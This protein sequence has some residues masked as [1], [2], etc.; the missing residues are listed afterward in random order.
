MALSEDLENTS[1]H[2]PVRRGL[3]TSTLSLLFSL[4]LLLVLAASAWVGFEVGQRQRDESS[5]ATQVAGLSSQLGLAQADIAAGRNGWAEERLRFILSI[6]PDF[7][8]AAA[9]LDQIAAEARL[10]SS[11]PPPTP[12]RLPPSNDPAV[13]LAQVDQYLTDRNWDAAIEQAAR[14]RT[15]DPDFEP[16]KVDQALYSALRNRGVA[17]IQGTEIE[18]GITDIDFAAQ[19]SPLDQEAASFREYGRMYLAARGF[20]GLD[21]ARTVDV[22]TEL[23]AIGPYFRDAN[24][25]LYEA[26]LA[27]ARELEALGDN[28]S[29]AEQYRLSQDLFSDETT[30]PLLATAEVNCQLTPFP[31]LDPTPDPNATPAPNLTPPAP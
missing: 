9:L 5:A 6:D 31:P 14:L 16:L 4:G 21:W 25:M 10:T 3:S 23:N 7:P 11:P 8:E 29:A 19:F 28:C 24:R 18:L 22:L 20:W 30:P 27:Y 17:R 13:I 26:R 2:L 12:T 15:L 1:R